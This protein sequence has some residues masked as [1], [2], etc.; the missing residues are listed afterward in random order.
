MGVEKG[1][2]CAFL[3]KR[4]HSTLKLMQAPVLLGV[5]ELERGLAKVLL[6]LGADLRFGVEAVGA[7]AHPP[8][9][10][11]VRRAFS[12]GGGGEDRS[13]GGAVMVVGLIG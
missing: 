7:C 2:I 9:V 11:L 8:G 4:V 10:L 13:G 1:G 12:G 5:Q 3:F 6:V